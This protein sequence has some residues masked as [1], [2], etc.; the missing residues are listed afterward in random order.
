MP[1]DIDAK[2]TR[3]TFQKLQINFFLNASFSLNV[4]E[5]LRFKVFAKIHF[6]GVKGERNG[7]PVIKIPF[8]L[9]K[10]PENYRFQ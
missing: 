5:H 2:K 8:S 1:G 3:K 9:Q 6:Q 4:Y 10:V 7:I